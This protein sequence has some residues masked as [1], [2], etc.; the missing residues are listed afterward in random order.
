MSRPHSH[1]NERAPRARRFLGEQTPV[2][3]L[4]PM[5]PT[6]TDA[7]GDAARP[8]GLADDWRQVLPANDNAA[9]AAHW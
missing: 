8:R 7:S 9:P 5:F 6:S 2:F 4:L 3:A 1:P